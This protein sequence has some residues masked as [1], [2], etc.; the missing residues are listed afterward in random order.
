[1]GCNVGFKVRKEG[2]QMFFGI[3]GANSQEDYGAI[4]NKSK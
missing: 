2:G 4:N 1:V 3:C